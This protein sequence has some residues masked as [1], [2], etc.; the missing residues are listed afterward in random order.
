MGGHV[1][2]Y[3]C[4]CV[5]MCA[6]VCGWVWVWVWVWAWVGAPMKGRRRALRYIVTHRKALLPEPIDTLW[7]NA[8]GQVTCGSQPE[9]WNTNALL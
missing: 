4:E 1:C 9:Q 8:D 7:P 3:V 5:C 2:V 6:W